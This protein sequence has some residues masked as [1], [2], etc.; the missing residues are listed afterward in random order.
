LSVDL[1][2]YFER[3][4]MPTPSSWA[5]AIAD[6]GF[7]AELHTEFDVDTFSGFLPCRFD[8]D[9]AGFEYSSGPI[10]LVDELDLPGDFDFSVT[11]STHSNMREL[12]ASVVCAAVLCRLSRGIL[13]DPQADEVVAAD[14]AVSW[15]REMLE[16][17]DL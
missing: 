15:A 1:T 9:D 8:G 7:P 10:E 5:D 17:I 3:G 16:E 2:V 13:V 6:S 4:A 12:A 11:F 14:D